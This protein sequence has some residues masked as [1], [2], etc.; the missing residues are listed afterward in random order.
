[1][2]APHPPPTPSSASYP[3]WRALVCVACATRAPQWITRSRLRLAASEITHSKFKRAKV[4]TRVLGYDNAHAVR[5][6]K[7]FKFA[8]RRLPYDHRHRTSGDKGVPYEFESP[9]RLLED[10]FA[11]VDRV[12]KEAQE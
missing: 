7:K 1:M 10:F 3:L 9:Q 2:L 11:E 6:P 5:P 12:I 8:G 4:G